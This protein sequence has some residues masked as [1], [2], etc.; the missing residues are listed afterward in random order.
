MAT[1]GTP[2]SSAAS[3]ADHPAIISHYATGRP[4]IFINPNFTVSISG[5][6]LSEKECQEI[7]DRV[8]KAMD[9]P[10]YQVAIRWQEVEPGTIACWDNWGVM[11]IAPADYMPH[12]RM[13]HRTVTLGPAQPQRYTGKSA[14]SGVGKLIPGSLQ[15]TGFPKQKT[16]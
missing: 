6:G 3:T 5:A 1:R 11:H 8:S 10:D 16:Q 2:T 12:Y 13:M 7:F 9:H 15:T 14:D 4:H